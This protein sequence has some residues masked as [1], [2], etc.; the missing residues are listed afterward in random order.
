MRGRE[1]FGSQV[2]WT[3]DLDRQHAQIAVAPLGV[4][5]IGT[6]VVV[7]KSDRQPVFAGGDRCLQLIKARIGGFGRHVDG[8]QGLA[9]EA[10]LHTGRFVARLVAIRT[11]AHNVFAATRKPLVD[12]DLTRTGEHARARVARTAGGGTQLVSRTVELG[13]GFRRIAHESAVG[14]LGRRVKILLHQQRRQRQHVADVVEAIADVVGGKIVGGLELDGQQIANRVGILGPVEPPQ[15]HVARIDSRVKI[16]RFEHGLDRGDGAATF[17]FRGLLGIFRRHELLAEHAQGPLPGGVILGVSAGRRFEPNVA[18]G[19]V[20]AV[21]VGAVRLGKSAQ[22]DMGVRGG[23]RRGAKRGRQNPR[24][25]AK[26]ASHRETPKASGFRPGGTRMPGSIQA[27]VR[28][29]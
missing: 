27:Q 1:V 2:E 8:G 15:R 9:I 17:C 4:G 26:A 3:D 28:N 12:V 14:D 7:D 19:R 29:A 25:R 6:V 10:Q 23:S 24:T 11:H 21:A 13:R 18:L 22:I 16:G 20:A 5:I